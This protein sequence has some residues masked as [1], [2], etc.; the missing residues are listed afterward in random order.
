MGFGRGNAKTQSLMMQPARC[1]LFGSVTGARTARPAWAALRP[2]IYPAFPM[3]NGKAFGWVKSSTRDIAPSVGAARP[4]VTT[5][6]TPGATPLRRWAYPA[7]RARR[8]APCFDF[9]CLASVALRLPALCCGAARGRS[10]RRG[11]VF[12]CFAVVVP[13][14]D[15]HYLTESLHLGFTLGRVDGFHINQRRDSYEHKTPANILNRL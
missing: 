15:G 7:T 10:K 14:V 5:T 13:L 1:G 9:H 4:S 2:W 11:R 3:G 12:G 6:P 8:F